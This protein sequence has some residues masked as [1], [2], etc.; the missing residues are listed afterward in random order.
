M[1]KMV[2]VLD[3]H[4]VD[5]YHVGNDQQCNSYDDVAHYALTP[6]TGPARLKCTL[7]AIERRSP[8]LLNG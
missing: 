5:R 8:S 2:W 4:V 1:P 3:L 6:F 7:N